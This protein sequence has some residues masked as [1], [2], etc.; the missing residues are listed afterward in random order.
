MATRR[1]LPVCLAATLWAAG[2]A[3]AT[4][5]VVVVNRDSPVKLLSR[6]QVSDLYLG[7]VRSVVPGKLA[8]ILDQPRESALRR[9]FFEALLDGVPIRQVNAYW[10]RLQFSGEL[11]PPPE[12]PNDAAVLDAVRRNP[13]A[14]GYVKADG[15]PADVRVVLRLAGP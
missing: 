9:A 15:L 1:L 13:L 6:A 8:W 3:A 2:G 14:I 12:L 4:E 11:Q 7:R 5:V 10:T